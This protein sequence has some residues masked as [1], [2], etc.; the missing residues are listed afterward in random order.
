MMPP[1]VE[2]T[3]VNAFRAAFTAMIQDNEFQQDA[4]RQKLELSTAPWE[5][6]QASIEEAYKATRAQIEIAKKYYQ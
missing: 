6:V 1:G 5:D 4:D 3:K 2:A